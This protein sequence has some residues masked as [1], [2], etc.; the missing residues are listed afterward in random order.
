MLPARSKLGGRCAPA[1]SQRAGGAHAHVPTI[2]LPSFGAFLHMHRL[3]TTL[4]VCVQDGPCRP[5][6][7]ATLQALAQGKAGQPRFFDPVS[8]APIG[9]TEAVSAAVQ[10]RAAALQAP[11]LLP[12]RSRAA[13]AHHL[14][15]GG[16][17]SGAELQY[18]SLWNAFRGLHMARSD[19][20]VRQL[21]LCVLQRCCAMSR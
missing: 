5:T 8:F 11:P 18:W 13:W 3:H 14:E 21:W 2:P 4:Q 9:P 10:R 7:L 15:H 6:M 12:A 16:D 19:A 17:M 1:P 20:L